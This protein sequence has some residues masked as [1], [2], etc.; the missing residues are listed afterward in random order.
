[1]SNTIE[2]AAVAGGKIAMVVRSFASDVIEIAI[3]SASAELV[4]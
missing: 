4:S 2:S 1:M 3:G